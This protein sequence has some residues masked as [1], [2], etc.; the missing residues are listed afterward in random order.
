[1]LMQKFRASEFRAAKKRDVSAKLRFSFDETNQHVID[2][3]DQHAA[4]LIDGISETTRDE[5]NN[6]IAE[7]LESGDVSDLVEL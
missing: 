6:A 7:A 5:L 3:A 2:W 1:M 4:E